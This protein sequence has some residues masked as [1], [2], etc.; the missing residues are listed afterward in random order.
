MRLS[1]I[2]LFVLLDIYLIMDIT[3]QVIEFI[4][5]VMK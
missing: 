4:N 1:I 2:V 5:E 3:F